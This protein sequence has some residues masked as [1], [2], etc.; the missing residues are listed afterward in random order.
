MKTRCV[1][2]AEISFEISEN[3]QPGAPISQITTDAERQARGHLE[4]LMPQAAHL[5]KVKMIRVELV[6]EA[7]K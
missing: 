6:P 3:W 2:T 7:G 4:T 5:A 1:F